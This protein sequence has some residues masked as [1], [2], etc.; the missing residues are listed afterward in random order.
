MKR[1]IVV[2]LSVVL[3][4]IN[5]NSQD[6]SFPFLDNKA[7]GSYDFIKAN[8]EFDGRGV[9]IF[10]LDNSVDP[11]IP[12]LLKNPDGKTKV[13]DLQDFSNQIVL[14]LK[15]AN[16]E[17]I[18]NE[19]VLTADEMVISGWNKLEFKPMDNK[20][21]FA[22]LGESQYFKNSTVQDINQNGKTDDKFVFLTFKISKDDP[23]ISKLTGYVKPKSDIW[24]YYCDTDA[25]GNIDDESPKF[26]YKYNYDFLDFQRGVKSQKTVMIISA[27]V[28]ES[29]KQL[30]VY[31]A[32]GSHGTHCAGIAAGNEIYGAKGN[33]GIAP[34]AYI[35]SL[36]IGDNTLSGG[37]TTTSSMKHAYEYGIEFMKEAGFKYAVFSMSYGIGSETP[38][39]SEIEIFLDEFVKKN[40][41]AVVVNS[42]GNN[43]PGINSTGNPAGAS[44]IISVGAMLPPQ[45]LKN[46]YGSSRTKNWITHFSSRGGESSK[47]DIVAPGGASS[48]VPQF[49]GGD[50]FWGTSM[51]CPQ[52]AGAVALLLSGALKDNLQVNN[53]MIRKAL[54]FTAKPMEGYTNIDYGNGLVNIPEAYKLL[55]ILAERDEY[56]KIFDY[57]IK[58]ANTYYPDKIGTAAFWKAGGY[59]PTDN[60]KQTVSVKAIYPENT[61][62]DIQHNFYRVLSLS[63]DADW[64]STDKSDIYVRGELA[65]TFGL[66][67]DSKKLNKP[68][69]YT[70]RVFGKAKNEQNGGFN[71]F[72]MQAT[73]VI[74]Y[75]F[76]SS[77]DYKLVLKNRELKIGDIE[78]IFLE[79]PIGASAMTIKISPIEKKHFGMAAYLFKPDGDKST[80]SVSTDVAL[81]KEILFNIKGADL[82]KGIWELLPYS[83]YQSKENSNFDI[84]VQFYVFDSEPELINKMEF[85]IGNFP[86][87][88][89]SFT[90]YNQN[91]IKS[92]IIGNILGY[93]KS[94]NVNFSEGSIYKQ[95]LI[96]GKDIGKVT[97]SVSMDNDNYNKFTDIA[98]NVYDNNRKSIL[99]G[100]VSRKTDSFTF[101]P[102]AEGE[103]SIELNGGFTN[104]N[105]D[106]WKF[107]LCENYYYKSPIALKFKEPNLTIY[108]IIENK[109]EFSAISSIPFTPNNCKTFGEI[110]LTNIQNQDIILTKRIEF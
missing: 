101:V 9:V 74:P 24:V 102:P 106:S 42:N 62:K 45:I 66:N 88:E 13:I 72:D 32:D 80:M 77:N 82:R 64:L 98:F 91:I 61:S 2:L 85:E 43:G 53:S 55:K 41:N 47:P 40:P 90:G 92:G 16:E 18:K 110:I 30:V 28:N 26:E 79:T 67:Y 75:K 14:N 56:N 100:G 87:G 105:S 37:A 23:N 34:A 51:A 50:A 27:S 36:K 70:G 71:D 33:D 58:T 81:R 20:Y 15:V 60:E 57:E 59:F 104:S 19:N 63:S 68:G 12:G 6:N 49:E 109:V 44:G 17:K 54:K 84:E 38:G 108:P 10:I 39:R 103:Y 97:I 93:T 76:E 46:L 31:A 52:V 21:Y 48:T 65:A 25:D 73:V 95:K 78:R 86:N 11:T 83:F 1:F 99:S 96:I 8:P 107:L 89:F 5:L 4:I 94:E 69:I 3:G 7:M 35:A 22:Q 29:K